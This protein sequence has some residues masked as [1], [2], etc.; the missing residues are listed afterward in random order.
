MFRNIIIAIG[1]RISCP[2]LQNSTA[3]SPGA[4]PATPVQPENE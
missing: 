2:D 4:L 1:V 3:Q